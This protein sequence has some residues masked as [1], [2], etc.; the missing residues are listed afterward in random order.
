[1]QELEPASLGA[2][3]GASVTDFLFVG[4]PC[5]AIWFAG[6][7]YVHLTFVWTLICV[8]IGIVYSVGFQASAWQ[9]T[10]GMR[11]AKIYI[12]RA[13]GAGRLSSA[14][15][16]ARYFVYNVVFCPSYRCCG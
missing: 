1:M 3:L 11:L 10:P 13:E 7:I 8:A 14:R 4:F 5:C 16:L 2:R 15:A 6:T 12:V 9:A